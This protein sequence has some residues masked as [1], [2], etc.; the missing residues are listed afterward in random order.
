M[1]DWGAFSLSD[2]IFGQFQECAA[3]QRYTI[4]K[5]GFHPLQPILA[6]LPWDHIS[7]DLFQLKTSQD[8]YNFVL[9]VDVCTRMDFF[10]P[11]WQKTM[12]EIAQSRFLLFSPTM[13][14]NSST[15][16]MFSVR[17][18]SANTQAC[19]PHVKFQRIRERHCRFLSRREEEKRG[20]KV[21][22][23]WFVY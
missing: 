12:L 17:E 1:I 23:D 3:C 13:E 9:I 2:K 6:S 18:I 19:S 4:S 5:T 20:I 22:A 10:H 8:G 15:G 21:G 16:S 11:I 7:F 14:Q